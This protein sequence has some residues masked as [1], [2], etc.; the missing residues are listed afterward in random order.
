MATTIQEI[1]AGVLAAII[2]E[3]QSQEATIETFIGSGEANVQTI[4][5]NLIKQIPSVKGVA[6]IVVGPIETALEAGIE[7]YVAGL[8][9]KETP[10]TIFALYIALLQHLA[11]LV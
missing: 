8:I 4:L 11:S 3:S 1:E 9:A 6:A 7:T 2:A 5:V 10:A